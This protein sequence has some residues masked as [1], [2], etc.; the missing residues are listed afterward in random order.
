MDRRGSRPEERCTQPAMDPSS[1][2]RDLLAWFGSRARDLPWRETSDPYRVWVSEVMLQQT[3]VDTVIPYYHRWLERFPDLGSLAR[4]PEEEVLGVW[5][6]LGYYSRARNLHRAAR[7]VRERHQGQVPRDPGELRALPGVG[8][9][10]VGAVASIAFGLPLPAVDGNVRRVMARLTDSPDPSRAELRRWAAD[11][12]DPDRPGDF[13][14]ALM[15]LGATV[16]TPRSPE[17]GLCPVADSCSAR[18]AGTQGERPVPLRRPKLR[19]VA[20]GVAVLLAQGPDSVRALVRRRDP[21]GLLGGMWEFPAG[22]ALGGAG[23]S[24]SALRE[25]AC[26][27]AAEVGVDPGPLAGQGPQPLAPVPHLFSHLRAVYHPFLWW[28]KEPVSVDGGDPSSR[29]MPVEAPDGTPL[30]VAQRKILDLARRALREDSL[31]AGK[32][33]PPAGPPSV[34]GVS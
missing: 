5:A 22:T 20:W 30:P 31:R 14:Q 27:A 4:A 19:E 25:A 11:L 26:L 3:R 12:V 7:V 9:Y 24:S 23:P 1:F 28:L 17:C 6:G 15:E 16:C 2:R 10:T 33:L 8:E 18:R 34:D 13:N 32:D 29:W 21:D